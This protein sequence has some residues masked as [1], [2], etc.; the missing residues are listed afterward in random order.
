MTRNS[1]NIVRVAGLLVAAFALG[2]GGAKGAGGGKG[3]EVQ[4]GEDG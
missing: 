4:I 2:C 3:G 1:K